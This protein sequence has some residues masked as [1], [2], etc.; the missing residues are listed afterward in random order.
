MT[1]K[2]V[3]SSDIITY[4]YKPKALLHRNNTILSLFFNIQT[5]NI[6]FQTEIVSMHT[7]NTCV[8]LFQFI[9]TYLKWPLTVLSVWG[10]ATNDLRTTTPG[11]KDIVKK[12]SI[13]QILS[14]IFDI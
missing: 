6:L 10:I 7:L 2:C 12:I 8:L 11:K 13:S 14:I 9:H 1:K 5:L 3:F 4:A